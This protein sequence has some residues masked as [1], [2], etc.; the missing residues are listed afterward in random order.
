MENTL[1]L[2]E[3]ASSSDPE[4]GLRAVAG[5]LA[6][7]HLGPLPAGQLI[8][9]GASRSGW[10][11]AADLTCPR[12]QISSSVRCKYER[13]TGLDGAISAGRRAFS[14]A[15]PI[16]PC[17]AVYRRRPMRP[18]TQGLAS[19]PPMDDVPVDGVTERPGRRRL[20]FAS[21]WYALY[22][23]EA[24]VHAERWRCIKYDLA[25][26]RAAVVGIAK[27]HGELMITA[28]L[29]VVLAA[30]RYL[31]RPSASCGAG[32]PFHR[33]R[34][35]PRCTDARSASQ[36]TPLANFSILASAVRRC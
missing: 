16:T 25:A 31:A 7:R 29:A 3:G 17:R 32:T 22:A 35:L 24:G 21:P 14:R 11:N 27:S 23:A 20:D 28:R 12:T 13:P 4:V 6:R 2:A 30:M 8:P 26:V 36:A 9:L 1:E 34:S 15:S 33:S 19:W 18:S 10:R 5:N